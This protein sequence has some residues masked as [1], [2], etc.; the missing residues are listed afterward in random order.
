MR[1]S[2]LGLAS[3]RSNAVNA[4]INSGASKARLRR[5]MLSCT[6]TPA[7][8]RRSIARLVAWNDRPTSSD[9][10]EVVSTGA[11]GRASIRRLTAE[12]RRVRPT[13]SRQQPSVSLQQNIQGDVFSTV[14]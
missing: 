11:A 7:S 9:A 2:P 4:S 5:P 13:R 14:H 8:T 1:V 12:S 6:S 10:V 3:L